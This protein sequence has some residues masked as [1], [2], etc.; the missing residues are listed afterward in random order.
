MVVLPRTFDP[1][2]RARWTGP[3]G[4]RPAEVV[5]VLGGWQGVSVP[6]PG[7]WTLHLDYP[8][9]AA[10]LGLAVSTLAWGIWFVFYWRV[11]A[12]R[13]AIRGDDA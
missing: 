8:G 1:E 4:D 13:A 6:E 11:G 2:W 12:A 10:R 7:R 5:R 3:S 9:R